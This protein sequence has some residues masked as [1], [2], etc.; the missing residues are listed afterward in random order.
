MSICPPTVSLAISWTLHFFWLRGRFSSR[1]LLFFTFM[2]ANLR[3][4]SV[5]IPVLLQSN[6]LNQSLLCR[7]E[8]QY[9]AFSATSFSGDR[10]SSIIDRAT[11]RVLTTDQA[12]NSSARSRSVR[13]AE[14]DRIF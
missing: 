9:L 3:S 5:S 1:T 11:G 2:E 8:T 12:V 4:C 6:K 10:V 14:T 13:A 7:K